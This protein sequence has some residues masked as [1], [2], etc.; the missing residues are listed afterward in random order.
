MCINKT[1]KRHY[2]AMSSINIPNFIN[3]SVIV[4]AL[5]PY[6]QS[7]T[8]ARPPPARRPPARR[9]DTFSKSDNNTLRQILAEGKNSR[10]FSKGVEVFENSQQFRGV[11]G[12][13][14]I[15]LFRNS[16]ILSCSVSQPT[17]RVELRTYQFAA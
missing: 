13:T 2:W 16:E 17:A 1:P 4:F 8:P 12:E 10:H 11:F 15:P 14:F 3:V 7:G 6:N 5:W 9:T